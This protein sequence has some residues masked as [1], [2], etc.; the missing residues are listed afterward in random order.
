[1]DAGDQEELE[2]AMLSLDTNGN[3]NKVIRLGS[4]KL[5]ELNIVKIISPEGQEIIPTPD[6]I[7]KLNVGIRTKLLERI[8]ANYHPFAEIRGKT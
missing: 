5:L 6:L 7:R 2:N 8:T 3:E 4:L 1:M